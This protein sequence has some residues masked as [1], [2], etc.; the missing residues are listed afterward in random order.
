[1]ETQAFY[2]VLLLTSNHCFPLL[3]TET[4]YSVQNIMTLKVEPHSKP[5]LMDIRK[6][7]L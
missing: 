6:T 1:M 4:V 7:N 5:S 2:V 3:H